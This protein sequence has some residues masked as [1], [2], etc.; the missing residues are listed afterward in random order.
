M[1]TE[2]LPLKFWAEL[3][4][5]ASWAPTRAK[6]FIFRELEGKIQE[7][8]PCQA[9]KCT[10]VTPALQEDG[11]VT[12]I[13][14]SFIQSFNNVQGTGSDMVRPQSDKIAVLVRDEM[15]L[16]R[17]HSFGA[18]GEHLTQPRVQKASWRKWP[19]SGYW[20]GS[21]RNGFCHSRLHALRPW[22]RQ[23]VHFCAWLSCGILGL[24]TEAVSPWLCLLGI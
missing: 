5:G 1:R 9:Q 21:R 24:V 17:T 18:S 11:Q 16:V 22:G 15:D 7:R 23:D 13:N 10:T 12:T 14:P 19:L 20:R 4:L 8:K 3:F 2:Q 6:S